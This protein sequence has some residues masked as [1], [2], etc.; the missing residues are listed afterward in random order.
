MRKRH[1]NH[2]KVEPWEFGLKLSRYQR[3]MKRCQ[4]SWYLRPPQLLL[5]KERFIYLPP[6]LPMKP[7]LPTEG[8]SKSWEDKGFSANFLPLLYYS[9]PIASVH[10]SSAFPYPAIGCAIRSSPTDLRGSGACFIQLRACSSFGGAK[11]V[12]CSAPLQIKGSDGASDHHS[13]SS[14]LF[15][16][17]YGLFQIFL[18]HLSLSP[19]S[20]LG[21]LA[22]TASDHRGF[23]IVF[24]FFLKGLEVSRCYDIH[25]V[26]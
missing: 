21:L 25:P 2:A 13:L 12:E 4:M 15:L 11:R 10:S 20:L 19:L 26:F 18:L 24:F 23:Y 9:M 1:Q 3:P 16:N 5:L 7:S 6:P 14:S 22:T 8:A 17:M